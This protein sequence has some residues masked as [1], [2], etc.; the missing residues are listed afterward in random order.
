MTAPAAAV[1]ARLL[2]LASLTGLAIGSWRVGRL[3]A[4]TSAPRRPAGAG[5]PLL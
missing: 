3:Q 1:R 2:I 4:G 5:L